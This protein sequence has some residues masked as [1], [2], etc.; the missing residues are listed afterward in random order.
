VL[1]GEAGVPPVAGGEGVEA[2]VL[3]VKARA[4][5]VGVSGT[6]VSARALAESRQSSAAFTVTTHETGRITRLPLRSL[7]IHLCAQQAAA[8]K[9]RKLRLNIGGGPVIS[10]RHRSAFGTKVM[11]KAGTMACAR[12]SPGPRDA[13]QLRDSWAQKPA[14]VLAE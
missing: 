9:N 1:E 3:D 5:L 6:G 4:P 7:I 8:Q 2:P 11:Q 12:P 14:P 10:K 13:R